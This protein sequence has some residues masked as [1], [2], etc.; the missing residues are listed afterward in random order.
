MAVITGTTG[1]VAITVAWAV[2]DVNVTKWSAT[3]ENE[4]F[5]N[6][7]FG[8]T[9]SGVLEYRGMYKMIGTIEGFLDDTVPGVALVDIAV[10]AAASS[11]VL[12]SSTGRIYTFTGHIRNIRLNVQR[13]GGLNSY[14]MDFS[15]HG[16]IT[17]VA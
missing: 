4:F 16:A 11:L 2:S 13:T 17:S 5:N 7:V 6:N 10:G 3:I 9:S 12:T 15:S 14:S 1:S 8:E